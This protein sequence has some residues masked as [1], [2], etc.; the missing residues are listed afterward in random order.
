MQGV[1]RKGFIMT[2]NEWIRKQTKRDDPLGDLAR[3]WV[4][5]R[6]MLTHGQSRGSTP[7]AHLR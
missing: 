1:Q 7:Q 6:P 4:A 5:D 2:F 3:D